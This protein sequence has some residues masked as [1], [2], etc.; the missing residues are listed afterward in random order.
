MYICWIKMDQ[1]TKD[2]IMLH[3]LPSE[4]KTL[5]F[6]PSNFD[7]YSPIHSSAYLPLSP[8]LNR[9]ISILKLEGFLEGGFSAF[10]QCRNP[11]YSILD[12]WLASLCMN[13]SSDGRQ[14][15]T[16]GGLLYFGS[17]SDD[18]KCFQWIELDSAMSVRIL[19][20]ASSKR[21]NWGWI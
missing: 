13:T 15:R 9:G 4:R 5:I 12:R 2:W 7:L 1:R 17:S 10:H 16:G 3:L 19:H 11:F 21:Q 8:W 6:Y 14:R 18:W 20:V